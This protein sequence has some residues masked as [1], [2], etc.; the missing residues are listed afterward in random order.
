MRR[1]NNDLR[2]TGGNATQGKALFRKHCGNCHVLHREGKRIGPDLTPANRK[3]RAALLASIV[4]PGAV[5]RREYLSYMIVTETGRIIT[6]LLLEQNAA[7][8]TVMDQKLQSIQVPRDQIAELTV[9]EQSFMPER[10]LENLS[11]DERRHLFAY[12]QQ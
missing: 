6:G 10:I 2:L 11:S 5:I 7:S 8:V 9:L 1:Y 4:D 12:L 3:D